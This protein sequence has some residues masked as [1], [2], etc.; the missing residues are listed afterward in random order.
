MTT[1]IQ[2]LAKQIRARRSYLEGRRGEARS[3]VEHAKTLQADIESLKESIDTLEKVTGILNSIGEDRQLQAQ[4]KIEE[5][6]TM[7]LHTIF[8]NTLSFHIIQTIKGKS[9]SVE[10]I[11]RTTLPDSVI[12]TSVL[13][14]RGGG[15]AAIVG[16]L[17]R[18]VVLLLRQEGARILFLDETFAHVSEEYLPGLAQFL[19]E[20]IKKTGTQ[21]VMV[22]HQ[23]TFVDYADVTYRFST[24]KG[25]T[26]AKEVT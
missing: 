5:L 7:G 19:Q 16:F 24:S 20:I 1:D 12:D 6:V 14:A 21:I 15:L 4:N 23:D 26:T 25:K 2:E 18:V 22:T 10:F 9:A 8:D 13:D 17:L 11:I 3:V